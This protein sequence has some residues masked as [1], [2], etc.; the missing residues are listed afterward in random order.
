MISRAHLRWLGILTLSSATLA[1]VAA[2]ALASSSRPAPPAVAAPSSATGATW[3]STSKSTRLRHVR[4][5]VAVAAGLSDH[6]AVFRP[7]A[8]VDDQAPEARNGDVSR[9]ATAADG[10]TL[11]LI[12]R[13]DQLCVMAGGGSA[14]GPVDYATTTPVV[15]SVGKSDGTQS[16]LYGPVSDGF[17]EVDVTLASGAQYR[18]KAT[19]NVYTVAVAGSM[20]DVKSITLVRPDGS[21][22]DA[23]RGS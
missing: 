9:K 3:H 5:H 10:S 11:Y 15:L 19:N 7:A 1:T 6:F 17:D 16:T 2:L 14:C 4:G 21:K 12:Q 8:H 22:Q 20:Q 13:G 18:A 23:L